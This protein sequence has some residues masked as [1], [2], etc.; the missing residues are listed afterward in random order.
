MSIKGFSCAVFL[1]ELQ[2]TYR[3]KKDTTVSA[4]NGKP[5]SKLAHATVNTF[6]TLDTT[7]PSY[8]WL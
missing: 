6:L 3:L 2:K 8:L 7:R 4:C 1:I 5:H